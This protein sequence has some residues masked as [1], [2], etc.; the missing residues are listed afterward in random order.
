MIGYLSLRKNFY[1]AASVFPLLICTFIYYYFTN[2]A[3]ERASAFVPLESLRKKLN[4]VQTDT[5]DVTITP[6]TSETPPNSDAI[7]ININ[8]NE[9]PAAMKDGDTEEGHSHRDVLED[10]LYHADPDLYTD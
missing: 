8:T 3:Y 7:N 2:D 9:P 10:D 5:S 4:E 1:L 6:K